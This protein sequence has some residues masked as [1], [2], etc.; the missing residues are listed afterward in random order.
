M[1]MTDHFGQVNKMVSGSLVARVQAAIH[2][3]EF[4]HGNDEAR[5]AIRII[6]DEVEH[7]GDKGLDLDP[8]ET[9][10]WLRQEIGEIPPVNLTSRAQRLVDEFEAGRSVR[11]GLAK[12]LTHLAYAFDTICADGG[13]S[14]VGIPV[15]TLDEL[16]VELTAPTLL[17]RA[18]AGDRKSARQFLQELGVIDEH[19]QLTGP[20]APEP[21]SQEDYNR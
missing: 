16:S 18:L 1:T 12:V 15:S 4:P 2:D 5:A 7:R 17:D 6:A 8:G 21:T 20:Y 3:V 9:A 10:D 13:G 11:H 19:G 14:V